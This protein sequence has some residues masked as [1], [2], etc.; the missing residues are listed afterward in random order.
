MI[1]AFIQRLIRDQSG[2]GFVE[3]AL[4]APLLAVLFLGMVDMSMIAATR[5]DMEQAA[6]RTTDYALGRRPLN[7]STTYLVNEAVAASGQPS[8]NITVSLTLECDGV[9]QTSFTVIC[10]SGQEIRRYATVSIRKTVNTGF[11]WRGLA[12]MF[13]GGSTTYTPITVIGDS[14]VRLQ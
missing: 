12:A 13:T 9:V 8:S 6:Q 4:V 3:L 10:T 14:V 5:V 7:G 2:V 11:N 1:Y